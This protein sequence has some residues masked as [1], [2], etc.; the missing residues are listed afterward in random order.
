MQGVWPSWVTQSSLSPVHEPIPS[1]TAKTGGEPSVHCLH[2]ARMAD[3][4]VGSKVTMMGLIVRPLI[5]PASLMSLTK[6]WMAAF[7][8][9]NSVSPAKPKFDARLV[10]FDTG[11]AT[12]IELAVT[13]DLLFYPV[14]NEAKAFAGVSD[15]EVIHPAP[16]D[17]VDQL[18]HPIHRL[19]LEAPKHILELAQ[20]RRAFLHFRRIVRSPH[21]PF[22]T[23]QAP[24]IESQKAEAFCM[25]QIHDATLLFIDL[26]LQFGKLLPKT[27]VHRPQQPSIA[28][29]GINQ[30]NKI[31]SE[32]GILDVGILPVA[33][34]FFRPFQHSIHRSEE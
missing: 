17:R 4:L 21:L 13:P 31:I 34:G 25:F 20:Q 29:M 32:S 28:R 22:H 8:T 19:G 7:C 24:E 6:V 10:R 14:L 30:H 5:P 26:D 16:Q 9:P 23:A 2:R 11:K 1:S 18:N 27:F 3:S 33:C 12:V 15:G